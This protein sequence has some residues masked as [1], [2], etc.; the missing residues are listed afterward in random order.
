MRIKSVAGSAV[1]LAMMAC[2][3]R[4]A[5]VATAPLAQCP[6]RVVATVSNPQSVTYDLYFHDRVRSA[7]IIG[8][9][10]P[11]STMT[12]PL[13]GE[14]VGYVYLRRPTGDGGGMPSNTRIAPEVRIR[15]HCSGT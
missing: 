12:F 14:G 7:T 4:P 15:V 3:S 5:P 2:A 6:N 11:G 8:E 1:A 10:P 9:I 13:P